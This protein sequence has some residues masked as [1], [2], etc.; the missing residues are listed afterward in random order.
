[1]VSA[2]VRRRSIMCHEGSTCLSAVLHSTNTEMLEIMAAVQ[3]E[4]KVA[5]RKY[6]FHTEAN[7]IVT[8]FLLIEIKIKDCV[9]TL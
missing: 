4:V 1:M 2:D 9:I 7:L 3:T 5:E 6:Y 8:F